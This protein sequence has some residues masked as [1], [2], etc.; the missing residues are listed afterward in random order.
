MIWL[1]H[2]LQ[3]CFSCL[4][5]VSDL[6]SY[7]SWIDVMYVFVFLDFA[8]RVSHRNT[9]MASGNPFF[10]E[11][12][13]KPEVIDPPQSEDMLDVGEHVNDPAAISL[14]PNLTVS[15]SVRE[16]LECPV[17]LNAMYPPIHQVCVKLPCTLLYH[18]LKW[19]QII[20][21]KCIL[22]I[23]WNALYINYYVNIKVGVNFFYPSI[24]LTKRNLL[25]CLVVNVFK[26]LFF[27]FL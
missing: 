3:K 9:W 17:C 14:K 19:T 16:L 25:G 24:H 18:I 21:L 6:I 1:L 8:S 12:R 23:W 13:S 5:S 4:R 26:F 2:L 22:P 11:M 15:S 20:L 27:I 7:E 10:D